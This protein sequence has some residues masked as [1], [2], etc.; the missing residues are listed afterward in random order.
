MSTKVILRC[1]GRPF[2]M[3]LVCTI[4]P[5][6]DRRTSQTQSQSQ[7]VLSTD[8]EEQDI[9]VVLEA[10][11]GGVKTY[12]TGIRKNQAGRVC[13]I[14]LGPRP[15]FHMV[16]KDVNDATLKALG[17]FSDLEELNLSC[18]TGISDEGL[19]HL[20]KLRK[21]KSLHLDG[22]TYR[23]ENPRSQA[24]GGWDIRMS[25]TNDGIAHLAAL[26]NLEVLNL[27]NSMISDEACVHLAKLTNLRK[28]VVIST[29]ITEQKFREMKGALPNCQIISRSNSGRSAES[30]NAERRHRPSAMTVP[31]PAWRSQI[32][33]MLA[34]AK[35]SDPEARDD[36]TFQ[37]EMVVRRIGVPTAQGDKRH[38]R[39][40]LGP[41]FE[42]G[43]GLAGRQLDESLSEV[44]YLMQLSNVAD[45]VTNSTS[46]K[47]LVEV[48][49]HIER[50][51][52][53]LIR[54]FKAPRTWTDPN[55]ER[56]AKAT[57]IEFSVGNV[58]LEKPDG[59]IVEVRLDRLSKADREWV[60]RRI[61][62]SPQRN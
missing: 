1:I 37:L 17:C 25:C 13:G 18:C 52:P 7:P 62:C 41:V 8:L 59:K 47:Q 56:T 10:N 46:R 57:F 23:P 26:T 45:A 28:L 44:E 3:L 49:Y 53:H 12:G 9:R 29:R 15:K 4:C 31:S 50:G 39:F 33:Q 40:V 24:P 61:F 19:R 14:D 42:N 16:N 35:A 38:D 30:P 27:S 54:A 55:G 34:R 6:Q 60:R 36:A 43:L 58:K 2:L 5:A 20:A 32:D 22:D 11:K 48:Y 21:L 51:A